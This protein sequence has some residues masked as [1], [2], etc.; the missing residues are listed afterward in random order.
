M[1][2]R[3]LALGKGSLTTAA[4]M[5][6]IAVGGGAFC[7]L[8]ASHA[9]PSARLPTVAVGIALLF[10]FGR[11][12][13]VEARRNRAGDRTLTLSEAGDL[14]IVHPDALRAPLHM[15]RALIRAIHVD[16]SGDAHRRHPVE[17]RFSWSAPT[18]ADEGLAGYL[19]TDDD[20][21]EQFPLLGGPKDRPTVAVILHLPMSFDAARAARA[22]FADA[23]TGRATIDRE[24]PIRGFLLAADASAAADAFASW[25]ERV[26]VL[27]TE[28]FAS[29]RPA[30]VDDVLTG[31]GV[32]TPETAPLPA[33]TAPLA[34]SDTKPSADTAPLAETKPPAP[35]SAS[36]SPPTRSVPPPGA[37][38]ARPTA[39]MLPRASSAAHGRTLAFLLALGFLVPFTLVVGGLFGLT[40]LMLS[41]R[42]SVWALFPA[43][44]AIG[45]VRAAMGDGDDADHGVPVGPDA[46]PELHALIAATA[47]D[48]DAALP[49]EVRITFGPFDA[50]GER[51]RGR[52]TLWL[53]LPTIAAYD[54][55]ALRVVIAHELA[56]LRLHHTAIGRVT[57]RTL[58]ALDDLLGHLAALERRSHIFGTAAI[59]LTAL[60]SRYRRLAVP[61]VLALRRANEIAA[62]EIAATACGPAVTSAELELGHAVHAAF[63]PWIDE[64]LIPTLDQGRRPALAASFSAYLERPDVRR[65]TDAA[66]AAGAADLT[67]RPHDTH[68][69]L[70]LRLELARAAATP[71][72]ALDR[73]PA[74]ELLPALDAVEQELL[75]A[76]AGAERVAA[77]A[78]ERAAA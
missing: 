72:R 43:A 66:V 69:P 50:I 23:R 56:H 5:A 55:D 17:R 74:I 7:F 3:T 6:T 57:G 76:F 26:D 8:V 31:L 33:G 77:L 59:P 30:E 10:G 61:A 73:R 47:R 25:D 52:A 12:A 13:Q 67:L 63:R 39:S 75:A 49:A 24:T 27:L 41:H 64:K 1:G 22:R 70:G 34:A 48:I 21:D 62:D 37:A 40:A 46:A 11:W 44:M 28:H 16:T 9:V 35:P 14:T 54:R 19:W 45:L 32:T 38:P 42:S 29:A 20:G 36:V 58:T 60:L 15:P 4:L 68:P 71:A 18:A 78:S 2:T 53:G 65:R 51:E